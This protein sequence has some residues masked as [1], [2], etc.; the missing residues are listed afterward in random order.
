MERHVVVIYAHPDDESF[1]AAGTI[2][3]FRKQN[4]PVTYLCGTLGQ[5]G[6]NMGPTKFANRETLAKVRKQE[7][8]DAGRFLDIDIRLLG[9]HDKTIEFEDRQEVAEHIKTILE[10]IE[11][12]LVIT[13]YPGYA[14]HPDHN[15]LGAAT[16]EAVRLM[17]ENKRPTLWAQAIEMNYQ[18]DLGKPDIIHDITD[19]FDKKLQS[20]FQ[21]KSQA[22][23]MMKKLSGDLHIA[24]EEKERL[25]QR[26]GKEQF[27]IWDFDQE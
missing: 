11:P 14:I 7:L 26:L 10:E 23:G 3:K 2:M 1:G 25:L 12:S 27:F 24:E 18:D 17:D 4:V 15:A 22:E 5:M 20:I 19:N 13:H 9:Y 16:I 8:Y 6:R 21:H